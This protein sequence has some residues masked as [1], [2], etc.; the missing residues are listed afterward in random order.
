[1]LRG[2]YLI[3]AAVVIAIPAVLVPALVYT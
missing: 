3:A 1:M 2:R